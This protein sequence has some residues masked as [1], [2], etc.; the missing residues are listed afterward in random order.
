MDNFPLAPF[1]ASLSAEQIHVTLGDYDRISLALG[2]GGPWTLERLRGVLLA[3]L[4]HSP[5]QEAIF[6]DKFDS[7]FIALSD[8]KF[9]LVNYE[10]KVADS[11]VLFNRP[12]VNVDSSFD[13]DA[14][15][16]YPG[17]QLEIAMNTAIAVGEPLL[18]TGEPGTGKTQAAYYAAYKLGIEPIIHFQV[19]SDSTARDLL[20]NFDTVGY[21]RDAHLEG[22]VKKVE[23]EQYI[24]R[25]A[26]WSAIEAESTLPHLD[27]LLKDRQDQELVKNA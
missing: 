16:F 14:K 17:P 11:S 13:A 9:Q 19:K 1:L 26:L 12:F 23:K 22:S 6:L 8:Y 24:E 18:I 10:N 7:F 2:A 27:V 21:F 5:E 25:R 15:R 4:V 3:L 20:Y